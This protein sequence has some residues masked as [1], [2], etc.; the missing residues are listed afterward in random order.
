M[1][2]KLILTTG[3]HA[4]IEI[5]FK[6]GYYMIG[7]DEECQIR[8]SS[9]SVSRRHCLLHHSEHGLRVFDLASANGTHVNQERLEPNQWVWLRSDDKLRCGTLIFDVSV[10]FGSQRAGRTIATA[11][12]T[13][14]DEADPPVIKQRAWE[15]FDIASFLEA[16]DEAERQERYA[17]LRSQSNAKNVCD[18]SRSRS[19]EVTSIDLVQGDKAAQAVLEEARRKAAE[20]RDVRFSARAIRIAALR[21]KIEAERVDAERMDA[22]NRA[23]GQSGHVSKRPLPVTAFSRASGAQSKT[24]SRTESGRGRLYGVVLLATLFGGYFIYSAN[25]VANGTPTHASSP[26]SPF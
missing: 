1:S 17:A 22:I 13:A 12:L 7:R 3:S 9:H 6:Y 10:Q 11:S 20:Q 18:E 21:A 2:A 23:L 16:E 24:V 25:Q 5:P 4:G 19:C 8:P 14:E 15:D 26:A